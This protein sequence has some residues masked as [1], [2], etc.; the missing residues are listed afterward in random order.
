[1]KSDQDENISSVTGLLSS[2]VLASGVSRSGT[3]G[4][5]ASSMG[6]RSS[7]PM[8]DADLTKMNR[9]AR[10]THKLLLRRAI[11]SEN[12]DCIDVAAVQL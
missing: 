12:L 2:G 3:S 6:L 8:A 1:M 10:T 5:G 11:L 9:I 4:A 7:S